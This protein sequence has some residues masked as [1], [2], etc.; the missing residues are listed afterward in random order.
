MAGRIPKVVVLG[1]IYVDMAVRCRKFP[2]PG[3]IVE[4]SGFSCVATGSGPLIA[5]QAAICDCEVHLLGKVG[6]DVFGALACE[7]LERYHVNTDFI[8]KAPAI[9]TGIIVTMVDAQGE[10]SGCIS[11]GA[12]RAL[13]YDEVGCALA[14]QLIGSADVCIISGQVG[15]EAAGTAIRTAQLN[16]TKVILQI[17]VRVEEN[18]QLVAQDWP[19]EYLLVDVL[20]P[21]LMW[22]VPR[23]ESSAGTVSEMKYIGTE[24]V[25]KGFSA[26]ML[27]MGSRGGVVVDRNGPIHVSVPE[28]KR[29][30]RTACEDAFAGALAAAIGAGDTPV[31]AAKFACVTGSLACSRFGG[32]E[33]L[34]KK[35]EIIEILQTMPDE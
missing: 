27:T 29:V 13:C 24:L 26:V 8:Y 18:G 2:E 32:I 20:V 22:I 21:E 31:Q 15:Y 1:P 16:K 34:P 6:N 3:Q 28:C 10:N 9:S 11:Q 12:N 25:A 17:Q 19:K 7:S 30:D 33:A 4:G 35:A 5:V 14:E 23:T